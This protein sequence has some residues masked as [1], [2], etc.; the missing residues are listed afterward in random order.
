MSG[1]LTRL[2][3]IFNKS[4]HVEPDIQRERTI[5]EITAKPKRAVVMEPAAPPAVTKTAKSK[6]PD[7]EPV[8]V[9][10]R[11]KTRRKAARRWEDQGGRDLSDL[12]EDLL[13]KYV[14]A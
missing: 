12:V 5:P 7:Y 4:R 10:V 1:A 2:A 3:A 11:T 14:G 6:D 13:R 9:Y 8:K